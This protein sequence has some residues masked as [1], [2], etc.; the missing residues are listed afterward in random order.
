MS[1]ESGSETNTLAARDLDMLHVSHCHIK[2][3]Y[4]AILAERRAVPQAAVGYCK[5]SIV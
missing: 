2:A 5:F 1:I 3:F 4:V